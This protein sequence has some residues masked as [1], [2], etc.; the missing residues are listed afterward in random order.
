MAYRQE[1]RKGERERRGEDWANW[2]EAG[3]YIAKGLPKTGYL[4]LNFMLF[5]P[6]SYQ[7]SPAF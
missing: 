4:I 2:Q 7:P 1:G 6:L 5:M 3:A